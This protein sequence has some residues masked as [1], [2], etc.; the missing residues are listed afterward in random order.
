[1]RSSYD[2][3][4]VV[5]ARDKGTDHQI[6]RSYKSGQKSVMQYSHF[7]SVILACPYKAVLCF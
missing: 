3:K 5:G 4:E 1:M 6:W 7:T 2:L